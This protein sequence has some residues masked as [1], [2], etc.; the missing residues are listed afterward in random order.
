MKDKVIVITGA[1][2]GIG[3]ALAAEAARRGAKGV[4]L[5]AR[6]EAELA[7]VA[8]QLGPTA[9]AVPTDVTR[10][11]DLERLRDQT[12]ARFGQ[13]DVLVNNAGRGITR[14]VS[15]LTDADVDDMMTVNLKSV[16][17]GIQAVLPHFKDKK[18][19]HIIT[20]S[21]G[22]AR[23]PFAAMRSAYAASKAAVNLL[24]GS[25][26]MELRVQFPEIHC[27]TVMPGVVATDFGKNALHGGMDSRVLPGAQPVEE[28]AQ[29]I[30]NAIEK[31]VAECY[32]RSQM[33]ELAA[34]Y[35]SAADV[36]AIE[37]Q[38]PFFASPR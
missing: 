10:R 18:R 20:I 1:S 7:V 32:T 26:R 34:K 9:L 2:I 28:V 24:M 33:L 12:L 5:A 17:Y 13:L 27:T 25:L 30:A 16:L 36:D 6:R 31:P 37:S 35:F 4:V 21:S 8:K 3:A 22:L 23:F 15:E 14:N 29:V 38:P 19:G 11:A